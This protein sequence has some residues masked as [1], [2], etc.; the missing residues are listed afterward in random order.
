MIPVAGVPYWRLSSFYF[1][2]FALLGTWLPFWGLYLQA[3]GYSAAEVGYIVAVMMGTKIV[4]PSLWGWLAQHDG[5]RTRVIR[6]GSLAALLCF[7]GVFTG[8]GFWWLVLVVGGYSFFWNAVLSQFEV[9]TLS[10]LRG[11]EQW[12]SRVRVWG[13][14]GFIAAVSGVGWLLE[15]VTLQRLPV[16]LAVILTLIWL[17]SLMVSE[18][19]S[20]VV[21][22]EPDAPGVGALLRRPA[23]VAFFVVCF[24]L[25]V[26][27]GPYYTF[28]S[29]YLEAKQYSKPVI[30]A[31]WSLGVFAEVVLFMLVHQLMLRFTIRRILLVSLGLTALRWLLTAEFPQNLW[32]LIFSQ[33]LHAASFGAFHSVAV[34]IV[35]RTFGRHQGHGMG[36]Y[37]GLSYGAGGAV[38]AALSGMI[39][40]YSSYYAYLSAAVVALLA[41]L[42]SWIW[43]R[44]DALGDGQ[45]VA[46]GPAIVM[47]N[48][49]Q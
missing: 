29:I 6:F 4:A 17:S 5:N 8:E 18:R 49:Q 14:L 10:H 37:S 22:N 34:E 21:E 32:V 13:S 2:Y 19:S 11:S 27:Y 12:Y 36:L 20:G 24:L 39:W 44:D 35:R 15:V 28:F 42:I 25:Q 33:C 1:W 48:S 16:I 26:S 7:C 41:L 31:L 9:V 23:V 43:L 45:T 46:T 30:G 47:M 38:G 3:N 40:D